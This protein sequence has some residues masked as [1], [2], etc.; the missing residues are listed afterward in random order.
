MKDMGVI[1]ED[2]TFEFSNANCFEQTPLQLIQL[3]SLFLLWLLLGAQVWPQFPG[4]ERTGV[5]PGTPWADNLAGLNPLWRVDLDKGFPGPIV[6][7]ETDVVRALDHKTGQ[8]R[9]RAS[10]PGKISVPFFAKKSGDWIRATSAFD[11]E[12][13]Y[14]ANK[15]RWRVDFPKRFSTPKPAIFVQAANSFL[16]LN[17]RTGATLWRVLQIDGGILEGGAF[18]SSAMA[19]LAGRRQALAQS[20]A[21]L[22]GV[23]PEIGEVLWSQE[24]PNY[25][26]RQHDFHEHPPHR[27]VRL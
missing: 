1:Y 12:T 9:W 24:V 15:V 4:P 21:K 16:M 20:R 6:S 17:K 8:E 23:D 19:T 3:V 26:V 25:R 2:A 14:V 13:L 11:G 10:G 5:A 7:V 27:F 22:H 18:G